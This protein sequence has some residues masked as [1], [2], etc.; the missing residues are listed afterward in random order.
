MEIKDNG[1]GTATVTG[2]RK[3]TAIIQASAVNS[4]SARCTVTVKTVRPF[5]LLRL[6]LQQD[7]REGRPVTR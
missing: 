5:Q 2:K 7:P 3:G 4:L 6:A 1:D